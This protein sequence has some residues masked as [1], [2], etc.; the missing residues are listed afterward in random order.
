MQ[1]LVLSYVRIAIYCFSLFSFV[2]PASAFANVNSVANVAIS[3]SPADFFKG[4]S[5][6][7]VA[8][9]LDAIALQ[10][11]EVAKSPAVRRDYLQLIAKQGLRD[12]DSLYAD[13]VRVRISFEATRAGGL[14]GIAWNIT[15]KEP[16]SDLIWTQWQGLTVTSFNDVKTP[17]TAIAECDELSAL[18]AFVARRIGLSKRSQVGLFWP[19][20]NHT[21]AVWMV[22][23]PKATRIVI[24]TS[25]I[26]LDEAQS[27]NTRSFDPWKQKNIYDYRRQDISLAST[28]PASLANYFVMQIKRYGGLSQTELQTLRNQ[29]EQR[30]RKV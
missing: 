2:V 26:F 8:E 30:Q 3:N 7:S 21:V 18:F 15:D 4:K 28:M 11:N 20:S 16:Q 14:W 17:T 22:N 24:P 12:S 9:L 23:E 19:T 5:R 29:R 25:Q 10:A 1:R 6:V 13:Y 27:L